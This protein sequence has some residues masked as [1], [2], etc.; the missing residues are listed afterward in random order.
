MVSN[1]NE[2]VLSTIHCHLQSSYEKA[3]LPLGRNFLFWFSFVVLKCCCGKENWIDLIGLTLVMS[4][5]NISVLYPERCVF[6]IIS[7]IPLSDIEMDDLRAKSSH[8]GGKLH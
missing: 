6:A 5:S 4:C 1:F 8:L 2:F 3:K 7:K